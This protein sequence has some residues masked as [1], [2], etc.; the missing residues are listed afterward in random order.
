MSKDTEVLLRTIL[1]QALRAKSLTEIRA[2]I[3]AMCSGDDIASVEKAIA[4]LHENEPSP[5]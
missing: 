5:E 3:K 4:E 2:A 1:Y